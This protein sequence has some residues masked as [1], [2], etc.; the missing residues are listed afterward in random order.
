MPNE[1]RAPLVRGR[2]ACGGV[3]CTCCGREQ[4]VEVALR[5]RPDIR[6]CAD[7]I[8][9]LRQ[10]SGAVDVTPILPVTDMDRAQ[11]FYEAAGFEVGRYDGGY[12]F[13]SW[14][15]RSVFDLGLVEGSDAGT[16]NAA[17]YLIVPDPDGWHGRLLAVGL[18]VGP[19]EDQPWGMRE[20]TVTDPDGNRLRIGRGVSS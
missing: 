4:P 20:F 9:W 14:A 13:V 8:D 15:D 6:V 3:A 16:S 1:P 12:A 2:V 5:Y 11:S 10:Q 18:P 17:C 19:V 7:C